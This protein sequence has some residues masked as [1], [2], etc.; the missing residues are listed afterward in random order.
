M[1]G[2]YLVKYWNHTYSPDVF[3]SALNLTIS[4][5]VNGIKYGLYLIITYISAYLTDFGGNFNKFIIIVELLF[6]LSF[7][8]SLLLL[9]NPK[10]CIPPPHIFSIFSI[11]KTYSIFSKGTYPSFLIIKGV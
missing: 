7:G 5:N 11:P 10:V 6:G 3:I 4:V 2:D 1:T 9:D 8:I